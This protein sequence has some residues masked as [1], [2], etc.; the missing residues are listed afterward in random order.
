MATLTQEFAN[1]SLTRGRFDAHFY[2]D[3]I[4]RAKVLL[5]RDS[6]KEIAL[7]NEETI[8]Y[9]GPSHL[10]QEQI[11]ALIERGNSPRDTRQQQ[12]DKALGGY[13]Y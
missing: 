5:R 1:V 9:V 7:P 11:E 6:A 8:S 10:R 13:G 4:E 3:N 12:Y 2:T